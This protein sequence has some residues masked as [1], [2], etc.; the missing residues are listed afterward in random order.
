MEHAAAVWLPATSPSHVKLLEREMRA[1]ARIITGC[2]LS[3][4]AR[5][6]MAEAGLEP[7]ASRREALAA[8][9]LAKALALP[10]E[11]PS[12]WWPRPARRPDS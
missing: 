6:V 4:P 7:V 5:A 11:D 10:A 8:R 9:L 1:A 3:T 2:P 12:E